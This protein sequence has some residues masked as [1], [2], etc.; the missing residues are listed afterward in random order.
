MGQSVDVPLVT[1][2]EF[3]FFSS[4]K[5]SGHRLLTMISQ[6]LLANE[7][8]TSWQIQRTKTRIA[9]VA[10]GARIGEGNIQSSGAESQIR[11][12]LMYV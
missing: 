7:V 1:N 5:A 12:D 3:E 4:V 10:A 2:Q 6:A 11:E 8:V 9:K